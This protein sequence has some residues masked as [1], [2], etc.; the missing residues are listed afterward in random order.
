MRIV[1]ATA[2][3]VA[4]TTAVVPAIQAQ[5]ARYGGAGVQLLE[6][7]VKA[8]DLSPVFPERYARRCQ[9]C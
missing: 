7:E 6:Y 3:A 1:I 9:H 8:T 5:Q 2:I 4:M